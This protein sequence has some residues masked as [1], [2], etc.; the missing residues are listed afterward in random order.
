MAKRHDPRMHSAEHV[1]NQTM[2]RV[3]G[4]GRCTSAHIEK[5]KSKCDYAFSRNLSEAEIEQIEQRISAVIARDLA[6]TEQFMPRAEAEKDFNL[7]R[8]P[9]SAGDPI[10]I[11][12]I[13]DYD[14]CPCSGPHVCSTKELGAFRITSSDWAQGRLRIRFKLGPAPDTDH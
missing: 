2:D 6:V 10:R 9:D 5:K 1:L 12:R 13:G 7:V 14:A 4:C 8:L 3:Y 11:V